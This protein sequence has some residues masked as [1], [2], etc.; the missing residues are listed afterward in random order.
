VGGAG[1]EGRAARALVKFTSGLFVLREAPQRALR[2]VLIE[3]ALREDGRRTMAQRSI[4]PRYKL[5]VCYD[6]L[7]GPTEGY[8]QFVFHELVPAMESIG[9]YMIEV[10]H[11][12]YG[13]YPLR[14]LEFV[15]ESYENIKHALK[16]PTWQNVQGKFAQY[17]TNFSVSLVHYRPGFQFTKINN[18]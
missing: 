12:A 1:V 13:P 8:Y 2:K 4:V 9:L 18:Q 6:I 7:Q 5:L 16:T 14:Q 15:A 17:T 10:Y 11:T 3:W